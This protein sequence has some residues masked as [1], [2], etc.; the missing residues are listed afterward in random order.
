MEQQV[1]VNKIALLD[2]ANLFK[3]KSNNTTVNQNGIA[4][5][6]IVG[7]GHAIEVLRD[8]GYYVVACLEGKN[9]TRRR[10][11][12][13][14]DYK[15]K[16]WKAKGNSIDQPFDADPTDTQ[17][18]WKAVLSLLM[19]MRVPIVYSAGKEADD[20]IAFLTH[21]M[22]ANTT[23]EIRIISNDSD[24]YQLLRPDNRVTMSSA[25][26]VPTIQTFETVMQKTTFDPR[27]TIWFKVLA[28]DK[29]DCIRGVP[30]V[31][32]TSTK[33]FLN[34]YGGTPFE[35]IQS[36]L[37]S[38]KAEDPKMFGKI[39][40]FVSEGGDL[41]TLYKIF[42][43]ELFDILDEMHCKCI[44]ANERSNAGE[45]VKW[46]K[47]YN[48]TIRPS[49]HRYA[50]TTSDFHDQLKQMIPVLE[51]SIFEPLPTQVESG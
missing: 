14:S 22:I 38:V 44:L 30:G 32:E 36:L 48:I 49:A 43:L 8:Q 33:A 4:C 11:L 18:Q 34:A 45:V 37:T 23:S 10:R 5:G 40:K 47:K 35:S 19:L 51:M 24:F 50:T 6:G 15:K 25:M 31:G 12:L 29:A 39:E 7:V 21:C 26:Q 17:W 41:G 20:V 46:L 3:I 13:N 2:T 1:Q 16:R 28:G 9:S 27:N 42:S